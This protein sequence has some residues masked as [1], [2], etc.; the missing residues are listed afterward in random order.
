MT[1]EEVLDFIKN[2]DG[3][4]DL[5]IPRIGTIPDPRVMLLLLFIEMRGVQDAIREL[6]QVLRYEWG[7]EV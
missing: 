5:A 6:T 4:L 3:L 7:H 1:D 2:A